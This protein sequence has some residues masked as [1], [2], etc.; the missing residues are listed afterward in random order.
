[1]RRA[2]EHWF[3]VHFT[4]RFVGQFSCSICT[5]PSHM[6]ITLRSNLFEQ[7]SCYNICFITSLR[8]TYHS[9]VCTTA[10]FCLPMQKRAQMIH[11]SSSSFS[12]SST[13]AARLESFPSLFLRLT[14]NSKTPGLFRGGWIVFSSS[15]SVSAITFG[16]NIKV[17]VALTLIFFSPTCGYVG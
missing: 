15:I 4:I 10:D 14:L 13:H 17:S 3:I 7:L 8:E 12:N 16:W 5:I 2:N 6:S 11:L 1:M 9:T